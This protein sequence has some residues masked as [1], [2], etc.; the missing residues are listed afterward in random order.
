MFTRLA[1]EEK[2]H[3]QTLQTK[4]RFLQPAISDIRKNAEVPRLI[5]QQ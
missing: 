3:I 4:V 1:E 5:C 2:E